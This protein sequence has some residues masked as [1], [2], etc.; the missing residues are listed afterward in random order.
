MASKKSEKKVIISA[1]YAL[2]RNG[3]LT[4]T[5]CYRVLS[6]NGKDHY[7]CTLINGRAVGCDCPARKPCYH[8]KQLEAIEAARTTITVGNEVVS[9]ATPA[10]AVQKSLLLLQKKQPTIQPVSSVRITPLIPASGHEQQC[11][12]EFSPFKKAS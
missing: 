4:G 6:S 11:S 9:G 12:R 3:K 2:K 7:C 5:V 10:H 8:M 1:R